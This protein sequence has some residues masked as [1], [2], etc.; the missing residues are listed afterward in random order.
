M[1]I[2]IK[3]LLELVKEEGLVEDLSER[4][5]KNPEGTGFDVRVGEVYKI[6]GEG[7][8]GI[9]ERE[10]PQAEL[11]ASFKEEKEY[12]LEPNEY[13][14]LRTIEKVNLPEGLLMLT[15]PRSTLQRSGILLLV[16]QTQPGYK[17][18][19]VFGIKNLTENRFKLEL[20][21][22]VAHIV[23]FEIKGGGSRYRGQWQGG[24]VATKK[25]EK[26]V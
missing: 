4:E 10:T 12:I 15:F 6:R 13:L 14:L 7:F 21:A 8:L 26:Q 24:R 16:T 19:L 5:L 9:E 18:N 17:G 22:R 25:R 23:F 11:V 3:K 2:G 20:G 1:I